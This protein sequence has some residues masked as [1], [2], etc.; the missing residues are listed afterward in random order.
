M[1]ARDQ[2]VR[3]DCWASAEATHHQFDQKIVGA[4]CFEVRAS[5]TFVRQSGLFALHRS[6]SPTFSLKRH[7]ARFG[8]WF[9]GAFPLCCTELTDLDF[10][11]GPPRVTFNSKTLGGV[12]VSFR[13]EAKNYSTVTVINAFR[14]EAPLLFVLF[15]PCT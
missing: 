9:E 6:T 2:I 1:G 15:F 3:G 10:G 13:A 11:L 4:A 5:S 7:L 8:F 12:F 14:S